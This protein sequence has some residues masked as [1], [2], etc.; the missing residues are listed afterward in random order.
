MDESDIFEIEQEKGTK[1]GA[2]FEQHMPSSEIKHIGQN[3]T[4]DEDVAEAAHRENWSD[5]WPGRARLHT[6]G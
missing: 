1:R 5:G 2:C 3:Q 4:K 6:A